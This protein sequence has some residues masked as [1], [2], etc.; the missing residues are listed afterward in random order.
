MKKSTDGTP[1]GTRP[2]LYPLSLLL[3]GLLAFFSNYAQRPPAPA[4]ETASP[5]DFSAARALAHVEAIAARPRPVGSAEHA[6]ARDYVFGALSS[7]GL[8]PEIQR[9]TALGS[10]RGAVAI[11]GGV[12]N[13]VA[14]FKGGDGKA[15]LLASHYDSVPTAPGASDDGSG[16]AALLETARALKAGPPPAGDVIL[17]FTDAE[18]IGL[19]GARAF[20]KEHPWARD[21]G[22]VLNFDARGSGGPAMMFETSAG[23]GG[24]I[25]QFAEAAPHPVANSL[26]YEIYKLLPNDTDLTIFKQTG[27]AGLNFAYIKNLTRYHTSLDTVENLDRGSL[28]QQGGY[29]LALARRLGRSSVQAEGDAVYFNPFGHTFVHYSGRWVLPLMILVALLFV[30]VA[31]Y[32]W[33]K[34]LLK[35]GG[36][37]FGFSAFLLSLL[38]A[39]AS[40]WL[41]WRLVRALR[42]SY[43]EVPPDSAGGGDLYLI[44]F[45]L[46]SLAAV[47]AVYV[48][49]TRRVGAGGLLLGAL[50]GWLLLLIASSLLVPGGSYLFAWPLLFMLAGLAVVLKWGDSDGLRPSR[51]LV[52]LT[53]FAVP[54]VVLA[55]PV[56]YQTHVA[57]TLNASTTVALIAALTLAPV[58]VLAGLSHSTRAWAVPI[59]CALLS[60]ACVAAALMSDGGGSGSR[61]SSIFYA[62]N[63]DTGSG[64]WAG[65]GREDE[66]TSQF[67]AGRGAP[68]PLVE[69]FPGFGGAFPQSPAPA[70]QLAP[71]NVTVL[72]DGTT[73]GTRSLHLSVT[74]QR[75]APII[76]VFVEGESEPLSMTVNGRRVENLPRPVEGAQPRAFGLR[77]YA[78]PPEG[79]DLKLEVRAAQGLKLRVIDQSYGLPELQ[80][81]TYRPRPEGTA[82]APLWYNTTTMVS[83][84]FPL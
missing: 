14:R 35:P 83:R 76:G 36:A 56:I 4:P 65:A 61:Q 80:G 57:L 47:S 62:L 26:S 44:G 38:L 71:P 13:V 39:P 52:V 37:A 54:L 22:V 77:Y 25:R 42:P 20:A 18:E 53:I 67:F 32:G 46:L 33:R 21:V 84:S 49:F 3:L 40:V 5:A 79:L 15:V 51:S 60:L 81:V 70:A 31:F 59:A 23:N 6:A 41:V 11:A 58:A 74:S 12:E 9:T 50:F 2:L 75:R 29:A 43:G 8:S 10:P 16:V 1:R 68:K 64:A 82:L 72:S 7:L 34:G 27:M 73:D 24:L 78:A 19:L 17:L 63:A 48:F 66:W 28:Q 55:A 45:V 69:F 30:C